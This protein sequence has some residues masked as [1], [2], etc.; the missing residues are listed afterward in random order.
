L[1]Q[2][3]ARRVA[4][5]DLAAAEETANLMAARSKAGHP[6]DLRDS[7]IAGIA[8]AANASIATRNIR[9]FQ[10]LQIH[11]IDPWMES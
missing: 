11:L 10:D 7:M 2:K 9:H 6:V 3:L 5:F 4:V 8:L 1:S